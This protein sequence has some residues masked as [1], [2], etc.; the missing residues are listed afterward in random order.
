MVEG[1]FTDSD[2]MKSAEVSSSNG[3]SM[4]NTP[5]IVFL[6]IY[7]KIEEQ[8]KLGMEILTSLGLSCKI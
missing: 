1:S 2:G 8:N 4:T 6:Y 5:A 7:L 3:K